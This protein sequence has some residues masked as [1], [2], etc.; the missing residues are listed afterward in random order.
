LSG[1][2]RLIKSLAR[3]CVIG[4]DL[5]SAYREMAQEEEPEAEALEWAEATVGDASD[6]ILANKSRGRRRTTD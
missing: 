6:E 2:S 3:P 1:V 4:K 5:E